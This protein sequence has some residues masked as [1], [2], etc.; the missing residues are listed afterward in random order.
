MIVA[1]GLA[2]LVALSLN[3]YFGTPKKTYE[4]ASMSFQYPARWNKVDPTALNAM[5]GMDLGFLTQNS[6]VI[7]ADAVKAGGV[8]NFFVVERVQPESITDSNNLNESQ[9]ILAARFNRM[10]AA[11]SSYGF[12]FTAPTFAEVS[13]GDNTPIRMSYHV[14]KDDKVVDVEEVFILR[15]PESIVFKLVTPNLKTASAQMQEIMNT[16]KLWK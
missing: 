14:S 12:S 4:G 2:A 7:V 6:E 1:V 5:E 15:D 10:Q 16:V 9:T 8:S 11:A 3:Y 13:I